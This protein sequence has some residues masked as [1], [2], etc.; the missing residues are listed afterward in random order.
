MKSAC[1]PWVPADCRGCTVKPVSKFAVTTIRQETPSLPC[2]I[3][4]NTTVHGNLMPAH[5]E[6]DCIYDEFGLAGV[7]NYYKH[8]IVSTFLQ[9]VHVRCCTCAFQCNGSDDQ[10]HAIW[11]QRTK[12]DE[13]DT[14]MRNSRWNAGLDVI[15]LAAN[16][17]ASSTHPYKFTMTKTFIFSSSHCSCYLQ[18]RVHYCRAGLQTK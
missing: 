1:C 4:A 15:K 2:V 7:I 16:T 13:Y 3:W 11:S 8:N 6:T 12:A 10:L 17:Y 14:A 5:N 9:C 18:L